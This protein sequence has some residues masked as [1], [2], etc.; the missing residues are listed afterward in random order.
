MKIAQLWGEES[1]VVIQALYFVYVTLMLWI[2]SPFWT[3]LLL[4]IF[5]YK[6]MSY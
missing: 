2:V 1:R 6:K 5:I 4:S 3:Y